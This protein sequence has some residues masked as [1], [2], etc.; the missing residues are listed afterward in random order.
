MFNT[1]RLLTLLLGTLSFTSISCSKDVDLGDQP[2]IIDTLDNNTV[3]VIEVD[4][5]RNLNGELAIAIYNS[6]ES[7]NSETTYY[8]DTAVAITSNTMVVTFDAMDPDTYAVSIL[9][10]EDESGDMDM[11][12]FLNLIPQEG[13]GFSNNPE[14]SFS[15]PAYSVCKFDLDEGLSLSVPISIVY[16]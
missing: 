2:E 6:S 4:G 8:L 11:G 15:E 16:F 10:D 9:H 3:L 1:I 14:I 5:F 12:G 13:F 7:F